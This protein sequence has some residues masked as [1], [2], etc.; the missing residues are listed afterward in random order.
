ME[1][2]KE[3]LDIL[4]SSDDKAFLASHNHPFLLYPEKHGAGGFATYHTR[5]ADRGAGQK[6]AGSGTE[7]KKFRVLLPN[8][9]LKSKFPNK[10]LVGRSTEREF[11]IDHSTVSKRHAFLSL[12][13]EKDAYR[14]GDAGSTNGTFLNGQT[15]ESGAPVYLRDGNIVSFGDCDYLFFS[16]KGFVDLLR[17]LKAEADAFPE[18]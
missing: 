4:L 2:V 17:R 1:I 3:Y 8:Q 12:D 14:L 6:I 18:E 16:P 11:S 13:K 10:M 15:V 7:I 5:M 9:D